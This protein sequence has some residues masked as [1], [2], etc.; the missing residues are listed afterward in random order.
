MIHRACMVVAI[1]VWAVFLL[2]AR[3][4]G[5]KRT[6]EPK[7]LKGP[8]D[9]EA[10]IST[11]VVTLKKEK[12]N[13]VA[14]LRIIEGALDDAQT[15]ATQTRIWVGV[16]ALVLAG[17]ILIF[18]GVYTT[19]SFLISLGVGFLGLAAIGVL[20]AALAPYIWWIGI[21][22][23]V[24]VIGIA[25]YMIMNR[26]KAL[27]Q[28]SNAV[29]SSKELIPEFKAKYQDIFNGHIDTHI[30]TLLDSIRGAKK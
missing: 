4:C 26:E 13:L 29:D 22:G 17:G 6:E 3:S 8:V 9:V 24:I 10:P 25:L 30:D 7:D 20:A 14:R 23:A 11:D 27:R 2:G 5:E 15:E 19:R 28:V 16:G 21:G 12:A 1:M 18:L